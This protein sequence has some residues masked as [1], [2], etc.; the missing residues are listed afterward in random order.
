LL[1]AI[2]RAY[3]GT[4]PPGR[5]P[6]IVLFIEIEPELVDINI[7]PMKLE[8][9]LRRPE[10]VFRAVLRAVKGAIGSQVSEN[11][12]MPSF[13]KKTGERGISAGHFQMRP[14]ESEPTKLDLHQEKNPKQFI[15]EKE[16]F[17]IPQSPTI[18]FDEIE[19][20]SPSFWQAHR[21][22][23]FAETKGGL[24]IIDQHAAHERVLFDEI[25]K[26]LLIERGPGQRLLFPMGIRLTATQQTT[27]EENKEHLEKLGFEF[28]P[29]V[30][31]HALV[32]AV[33]TEISSFGSG[34]ALIELLDDL[35]E[36]GSGG[37]N[38]DEFAAMAAC[39]IAIKAGDTLS[40]NEMSYL[41]DRLFS[42][43]KPYTCPH[44][45]PTIFKM[46]ISELEKKFLR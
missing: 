40:Q 13:E 38:L 14:A 15:S 16:L 25:K 41:F 5:Y 19:K 6:Q 12:T 33:P 29:S 34:S 26:K 36:G 43:E 1:A 31:G 46:E 8:V 37:G 21:A 3:E 28:G 9:R 32:E 44:G 42:T 18:S 23:I 10:D 20:S 24:L 17:S 30:P 39:H 2:R 7:H 4:L 22:Y 11:A 27:L 45:R 35:S